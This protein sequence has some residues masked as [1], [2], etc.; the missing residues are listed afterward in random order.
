M[1]I[2][3]VLGIIAILASIVILAINPGKQFAQA[4]NT[5][6]QAN[7]EQILNAIG[8]RMA[9]NKGIFAGAFEAH[10]TTYTCPSIGATSTIVYTGGAGSTAAGDLSCLVPTYIAA[11]PVDPVAAEGSDTGYSVSMAQGRVQVC[12]EAAADEETIPNA[13]A[14]CVKR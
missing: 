14:I 13:G 7:I 2:L 4:R 11:F 10:D 5:Q 12:A 8:Q 6:R 1:E 9:D 3:V